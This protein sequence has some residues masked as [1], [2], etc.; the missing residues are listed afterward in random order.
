MRTELQKTCIG[1]KEKIQQEV[2]DQLGVMKSQL[3]QY[4]E[5]E[6]S[7][8]KL[9]KQKQAAGNDTAVRQG[10]STE[11]QIPHG[12]DAEPVQQQQQQRQLPVGQGFR[13]SRLSDDQLRRGQFSDNRLH[14]RQQEI[15]S[16]HSKE[17]RARNSR[18]ELI[19]HRGNDGVIDSKQTGNEISGID[20]QRQLNQKNEDREDSQEGERETVG[21]EQLMVVT[22]ESAPDAKGTDPGQNSEGKRLLK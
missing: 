15:L 8:Q 11:Q 18:N 10:D 5:G 20:R 1:E 14:G 22:G 3:L 7:G 6:N 17:A 13:K 12:D 19:R 2:N 16:Y 4:Q 9:Q 21:T